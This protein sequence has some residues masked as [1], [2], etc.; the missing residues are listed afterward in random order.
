MDVQLLGMGALG[1]WLDE[2][3]PTHWVML[4]P[5]DLDEA[6]RL[7]AL[8]LL[9]ALEKEF[10][11]T[12]E[13]AE[14]FSFVMGADITLVAMRKRELSRSELV[15]RM[16]VPDSLIPRDSTIICLGNV[17]HPSPILKALLGTVKR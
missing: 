15:Q 2:K 11:D 1:K 9:S 8:R 4:I 6:R 13:T 16:H 7:D 17:I 12:P 14:G 5:M 3:L 10:Y